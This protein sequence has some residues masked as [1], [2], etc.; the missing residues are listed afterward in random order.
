MTSFCRAANNPPIAVFISSG[1]PVRGTAKVIRRW[2][3]CQAETLALGSPS[4]LWYS[5]SVLFPSRTMALNSC[6]VVQIE[7]C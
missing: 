1:T 2:L 5:S 3:S 7:C 6:S 4:C